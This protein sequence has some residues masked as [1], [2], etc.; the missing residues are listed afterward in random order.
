MARTEWHPGYQTHKKLEMLYRK[1]GK[2]NGKLDKTCTLGLGL[3]LISI[4]KN[5][6]P[7]ISGNVF[8]VHWCGA[9]WSILL[10]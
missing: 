3:V 1:C 2:Y 6:R 9:L 7:V 10:K 4:K 8:R 5:Q